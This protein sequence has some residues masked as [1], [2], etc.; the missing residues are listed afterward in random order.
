[1]PSLPLPPT[2]HPI[3][4]FL[5]QPSS[6]SFVLTVLRAARGLGG[7]QPEALLL[8]ARLARYHGGLLLAPPPMT[9][10]SASAGEGAGEGVRGCLHETLVSSFQHG[11]QN[12]RLHALKALEDLLTWATTQDPQATQAQWLLTMLLRYTTTGAKGK[13]RGMESRLI[14]LY[15]C[16]CVWMCAGRCSV[17]AVTPT[18]A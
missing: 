6:P 5:L 12:V 9:L 11:E 3:T 8:L 10:D 15:V 4:S 1:M 2:A 7:L 16:V 17:V 18:M 14:L 13:G